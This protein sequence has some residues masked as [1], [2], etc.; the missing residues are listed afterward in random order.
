MSKKI[1]IAGPMSGYKNFNFDAFNTAED[2]LTREGWAVFNP[3]NKDNEAGVVSDPSFAKGDDQQLMKSGWDFREAY[4]W[5]VTKV[6]ESDAIFMLKGW[7]KSAGAR[8]EHAVA[9]SI[10]QRYPEYQ[11][12]YE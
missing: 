11:I 1:Y 4:L 3:A 2:V 7:E 12:I 5:D 8:G 6:I 10:Q 9:I